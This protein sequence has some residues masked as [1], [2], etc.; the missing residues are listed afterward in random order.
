MPN[1]VIKFTVLHTSNF[2]PTTIGGIA[3]QSWIH[4]VPSCINY[5]LPYHVKGL[6]SSLTVG[7]RD[8]YITNTL[9]GLHS[10]IKAKLMDCVSQ[11]TVISAIFGLSLPVT[12]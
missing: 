7:I 9:I 6:I 8:V 4:Y 11:K 3:G 1:T 5:K 12:H 2:D 10:I